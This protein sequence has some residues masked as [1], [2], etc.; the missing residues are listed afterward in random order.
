[1]QCLTFM[2]VGGRATAVSELQGEGGGI[3][4]LEA[5]RCSGYNMTHDALA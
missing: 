5:S 1:M 4:G 3:V 2:G